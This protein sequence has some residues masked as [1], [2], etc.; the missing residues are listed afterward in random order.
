MTCKECNRLERMFLESL[1][2]SDRAQTAMR[3]FLIA[4]QHFGGVSD[5]DEYLALRAEERRTTELRHDAVVALVHHVKDHGL[6]GAGVPS[7]S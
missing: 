5:M 1:V 4:H 2:F 6:V 3:C 7:G